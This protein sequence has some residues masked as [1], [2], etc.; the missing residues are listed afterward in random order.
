[1]PGGDRTGPMGA[2]PRTGRGM[3]Y[4]AGYG[5]PGFM[6]RPGLWGWFTGWLPGCGRGGRGFRHWFYRTGLTGWQ[7]FAMGW[8]AWGGVV[9]PTVPPSPQSELDILRQQAES[10]SQTLEQIQRRMEELEKRGQSGET[11]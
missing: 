8:P 4:C 10:L 1:M 6:N 11:A 5:V 9:P 7:R 2:G 3:G